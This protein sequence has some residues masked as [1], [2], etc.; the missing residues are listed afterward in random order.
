[1]KIH[2]LNTGG[3]L[4]MVGN[5]L[6]P[7]KSAVELLEGVNI[8]EGSEL[9]L[10][11]FPER[12]DSTN[13]KHSDRIEMG[14]IVGEIYDDHDAFIILHGTDSLAET[15]GFLCMMFKL[16]LQKPLFVIG[17][18]MTKDEPGTDVPMQIANTIR[19]AQA[20]VRNNIVGVYNVCI[21]NVLH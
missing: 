14:K 15:C 21:G 18:Q 3:T 17:A 16:S 11:D 8:T 2:I 1:M 10:V 19:V 9:S 7:A 5:P 13:V 6:R 12:Q 20:F 4:G